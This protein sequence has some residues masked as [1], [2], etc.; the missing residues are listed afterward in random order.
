MKKA[1]LLL[2]A[3]ILTVTAANAQNNNDWT[4]Q[5]NQRTA[6]YTPKQC[7]RTSIW[8]DG[9]E[10]ASDKTIVNMHSRNG[11]GINL[12]PSTKLVCYL[13]DGRTKVL[14]LT[15]ATIMIGGDEYSQLIR[16]DVF[17]AYFPALPRTDVIRIK[18]IDFIENDGAKK[19]HVFNITGIK[20]N[21]KHLIVR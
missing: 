9:I 15:E 7:N 12:L 6:Y 21:R 3:S 2:F 10:F 1:L 4:P 11:G 17:K 5:Q 13:K 16:G 20:I 14:E 18:K 19:G 8:I